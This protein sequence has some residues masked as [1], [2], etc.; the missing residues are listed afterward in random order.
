[1][2]DDEDFDFDFFIFFIFEDDNDEVEGFYYWCLLC[3]FFV[4]YDCYEE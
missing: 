3:I 2:L 1:M 4:L